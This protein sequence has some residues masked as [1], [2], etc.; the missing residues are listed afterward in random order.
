MTSGNAW[1]EQK[2][3]RRT[4]S[5]LNLRTSARYDACVTNGGHI[6]SGDFAIREFP[7][8]QRQLPICKRCR[9][10]YGKANGYWGDPHSASKGGKS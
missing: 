3:A 2:R 7:I 10:P 8:G 5:P 9:V 6:P 4:L 1:R